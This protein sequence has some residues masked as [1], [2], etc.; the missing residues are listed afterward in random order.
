MAAL[1]RAPRVAR[2]S[3]LGDSVDSHRLP[4]ILVGFRLRGIRLFG[5]FSRPCKRVGPG[6]LADTRRGRDPPALFVGLPAYPLGAGLDLDAEWVG[7][8]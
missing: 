2:R 6:R 7:T 8:E 5:A 4:A 1:T 3:L